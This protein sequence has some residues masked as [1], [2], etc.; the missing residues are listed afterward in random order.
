MYWDDDE[1]PPRLPITDYPEIVPLVE[2]LSS[3]P[4]PPNPSQ[5]ASAV[6]TVASIDWLLNSDLPQ[7]PMPAPRQESAGTTDSSSAKK[8]EALGMRTGKVDFFQ[9]REQNKMAL[10]AQKS[11]CPRPTSVQALCNEDEPV[12]GPSNYKFGPAD[13]AIEK[14]ASRPLLTSQLFEA[15]LISPPFET[16]SSPVESQWIFSTCEPRTIGSPV[17]LGG[18]VDGCSRRTHVGIA[19]IVNTCQPSPSEGKLKRKADD[20][21]ETTQEQEQWAAQAVKP[22]S[23]APSVNEE[24]DQPESSEPPAAQELAE[25]SEQGGE[26]PAIAAPRAPERPVKRARISRVAERL[27][28]AA[29]GGVTAGAMI[30]GTLIYTAPT[31]G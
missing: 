23:P 5:I 13:L 1:F 14:E 25:P 2:S 7:P 28:Y 8:A 12:D 22:V 27:G 26:Q 11:V 6:N 20:I 30:V 31:F 4:V 18:D 15:P 17:S 16:V 29:L 9:A 21:S 10:E 24:E 19:D 3:A